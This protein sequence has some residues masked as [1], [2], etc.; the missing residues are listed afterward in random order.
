MTTDGSHSARSVRP[1]LR[2][3]EIH[4]DISMTGGSSAG[5][6][7]CVGGQAFPRGPNPNG[8]HPAT[9]QIDRSPGK[10]VTSSKVRLAAT[11][12]ARR[13]PAVVPDARRWEAPRGA[14]C[15]AGTRGGELP[16]RDQPLPG[17][18]KAGARLIGSV[19]TRRPVAGGR[20]WRCLLPRGRCHLAEPFGSGWICVVRTGSPSQIASMC[21]TLAGWPRRGYHSADQL[22]ARGGGLTI[23]PKSNTPGIPGMRISRVSACRCT[24][25]DCGQ[26]HVDP[27]A[28]ERVAVPQ[29]E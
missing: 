21:L 26:T 27:V 14:S 4:T 8:G 17:V 9:V 11:V 18:R 6:G 19:R 16:V 5:G 2:T 29:L 1:R 7:F 25:A 24:S 13:G 20:R 12:S 3:P 15:L 22:R 28:P 23:Q 10:I